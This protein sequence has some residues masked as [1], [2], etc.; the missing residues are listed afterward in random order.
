MT[1]ALRMSCTMLI[2][3][4]LASAEACSPSRSIV[5]PAPEPPPSSHVQAVFPQA[6]ALRVQPETSIWVSFDEAL[7]SATVTD[8]HVTLLVDTRR[9]PIV[10]SWNPGERRIEIFPGQP[11]DL[12]RTHTVELGPGLRTTSGD[13]IVPYFWQFTT[14]G[15][16]ALSLVDPPAGSTNQAPFVPLRWSGTE[17]SG[18]VI[19]YDVFNGTDSAQVAARTVAPTRTAVPYLVA[20]Q[21]RAGLQRYFWCVSAQNLTTGENDESTVASFTTLDTSAPLDSALLRASDWGSAV[22][23]TSAICSGLYMYAGNDRNCAIRWAPTTYEHLALADAELRFT[24]RF[25]GGTTTDLTVSPAA[26]PWS[27]CAV[28]TASPQPLPLLARA[29]RPNGGM[30]VYASSPALTGWL[31]ASPRIASHG[32]V[33]GGNNSYLSPSVDNGDLAPLLTVR[34]YR[35]KP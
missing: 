34:Y 8:R 15:L 10:V 16:R 18:G 5:E 12:R 29:N 27:G 23:A 14:G 9:V 17:S 30:T 11:L 19:V 3:A 32:F 20:E 28:T 25:S 35:V 13:A 21:P 6:R 4:V 2:G 22:G 7:D 1:R 26:Q 31:Q 33:L 24:L